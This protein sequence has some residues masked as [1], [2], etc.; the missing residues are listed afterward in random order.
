[1]ALVE[2]RMREILRC[3]PPLQAIAEYILSLGG[4][5]IRPLLV[6]LC[7]GIYPGS[8]AARIDIAAAAEL[9]HT[10]SLLHDDVVD[11]AS[12]RRGRP[13]VN[14]RW[15]NS[16]SVLAGDFL[17]ARAF[18]LLCTYP[19]AL[20]AMAE[21][22][23]AMSEGELL[24]LHSHFNPDITPET[25]VRSII[26]K[27]ASLLAACCQC[28]GLVSAMP[29]AKIPALRDFGLH[30]GI[31][32]Q[33]IDDISDYA[34][35]HDESGKPRGNDLKHG[36]I[37]LPLMHLLANPRSRGRV[38]EL[39]RQKR[40]LAPEMLAGELR[41]TGALAKSARAASRYIQQAL[42]KLAVFPDTQQVRA[43]KN[44]A[45]WLQEKCDRFSQ[46]SGPPQHPGQPAEHPGAQP[47]LR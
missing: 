31:A 8:Q 25:Y 20:D 22:V 32:Y 4:K 16:T 21:A 46:D 23:A 36:I 47:R 42:G 28:G 3:P 19:Q 30:L 38:L 33:I 37:T 10:A 34:L 9:I 2:K 40:Q 12:L 13:S 41:E 6:L 26:G 35:G 17:F 1:L 15:G 24:Q 29:A 45:A 44:L 5:R 7:S 39:L 14:R 18:S 27:T 11:A 43:L